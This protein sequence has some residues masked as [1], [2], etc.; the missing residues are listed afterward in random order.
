MVSCD[1]FVMVAVAVFF[2]LNPYIRAV[3]FHLRCLWCLCCTSSILLRT[4]Y[5][6]C[7]GFVVVLAKI[8]QSEAIDAMTS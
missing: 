4:V 6:R 1:C 5:Y 7:V 8:A 2:V 3:F